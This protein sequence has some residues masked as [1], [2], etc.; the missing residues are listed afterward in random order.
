MA[1]F[2]VTVPDSAVDRVLTMASDLT[3]K[4]IPTTVAGKQALAEEA[5][6]ILL[7]QAVLSSEKNKEVLAALNKRTPTTDPLYNPKVVV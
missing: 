6:L 1:S 3:G 7:T 5:T 4:A 2:T